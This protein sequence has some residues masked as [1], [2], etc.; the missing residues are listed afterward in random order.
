MNIPDVAGYTLG[1]ARVLLE[2]A[3]V[4]ILEIEITS[5]PKHKLDAYEENFRV[6]RVQKLDNKSVN[7]LIC[8]PL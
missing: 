2:N 7:L 8:K 3:G 1:D 5:P 4:E 6:I